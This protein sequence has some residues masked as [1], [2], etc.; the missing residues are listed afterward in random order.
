[1]AVQDKK[2]QALKEEFLEFGILEKDIEEKFVKGSG[3]GGQKI[4]K[5]S[6]TVYLKHLPTGIEVK[7]GK[8]RERET[9]RFLARR[10]LIDRFKEEI[11]GIKSKKTVALEKIKKQKKRRERRSKEL[12]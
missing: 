1:M 10:L 12:D 9:N 11:L 5:T 7:C 6:S 4:N 3:S 8:E 2:V